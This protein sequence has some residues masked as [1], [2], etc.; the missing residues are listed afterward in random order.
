[1]YGLYGMHT[2]S[3]LALCLSG[4]L[5]A[6]CLTEMSYVIEPKSQLSATVYGSSKMKYIFPSQNPFRTQTYPHESENNNVNT[7]CI[8]VVDVCTIACV[9]AAFVS[10][11]LVQRYR[12]GEPKAVKQYTKLVR[13]M[14]SVWH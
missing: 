13:V 5:C 11:N 6:V 2:L 1:M 9:W 8:A 4:H 3:S 14:Y 7:V 10:S 12:L